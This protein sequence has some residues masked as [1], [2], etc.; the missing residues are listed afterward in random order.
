MNAEILINLQKLSK[1][2]EAVISN[3]KKRALD[4]RTLGFY[5]STLDR[6]N[7]KWEDYTIAYNAINPVE[8]EETVFQELEDTYDELDFKVADYT[9]DLYDGISAK[10]EKP[11]F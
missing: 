11:V 8:V 3:G 5:Q 10:T 1:A 7:K 6:L 4:K 2:V 9:A